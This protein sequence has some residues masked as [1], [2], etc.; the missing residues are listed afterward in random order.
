[1]SKKEKLR[2]LDPLHAQH[3]TI[4]GYITTCCAT[5]SAT[6]DLKA[7]AL[8]GLK[9]NRERN[10]NATSSK[11]Q[12]N[13]GEQKGVMKLRSDHCNCCEHL[14]H[15]KKIGSGCKHTVKELSRQQ[16]D[17]I[18]ILDECWKGPWQ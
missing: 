17:Y 1:M 2:C 16:S 8:G 11:K 18:E 4:R 3:A 13:Q 7:L 6:I 9:R 12:R 14:E 10:Q 15:F 5:T